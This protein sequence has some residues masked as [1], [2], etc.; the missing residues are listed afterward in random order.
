[1]KQIA[2]AALCADT[3]LTTAWGWKTAAKDKPGLH[4]CVCVCMLLFIFFF[5]EIV[6][7]VCVSS[8]RPVGGL[9]ESRSCFQYQ[10]GRT[11]GDMLI[12]KVRNKWEGGCIFI[13]WVYR[14]Q[15]GENSTLCNLAHSSLCKTNGGMVYL[16][17]GRCTWVWECVCVRLG[18]SLCSS[19][20]GLL[21]AIALF[22]HFPSG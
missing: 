2:T 3:V 16:C 20:V 18:A 6:H 21:A 17:R 10:G 22:S 19:E 4:V 15:S 8:S 7:R 1:M 9:W 14:K 12:Y 5:L 13:R 11:G